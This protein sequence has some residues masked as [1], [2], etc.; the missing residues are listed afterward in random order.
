[1][2][3]APDVTSNVVADGPVAFAVAKSVAAAEVV[4]GAD[5][6]AGFVVLTP[7]VVIPVVPVTVVIFIS[8]VLNFLSASALSEFP[9]ACFI[10]PGKP[11]EPNLTLSVYRFFCLLT[12]E[13][14]YES[15]FLY[16]T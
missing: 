1:M 12:S 11:F 13:M 10:P 7:P 6:T 15:R 9:E 5:A 2:I 16:A 8:V 3:T 4:A 14:K